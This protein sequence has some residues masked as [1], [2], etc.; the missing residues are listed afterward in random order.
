MTQASVRLLF[1]KEKPGIRRFGKKGYW[2]KCSHCKKWCQR[3]GKDKI[4]I[5]DKRKME[6]DH[7]KSWS[8]GGS[9]AIW[10]LQPLC[11]PCNRKKSSGRT[12]KDNAKSF[13][14]AILH[15]VDALFTGPF[16]KAVRQNKIL[17]ALGISKRK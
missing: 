6:V 10:N 13:I 2:Y 7:I 14:N 12:K 16:K 5:P 1:I 3:P 17:K 8:R 4:Q 11:K 9:D 15:P